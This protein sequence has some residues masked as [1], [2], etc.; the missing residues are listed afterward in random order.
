MELQANLR[1]IV[2]DD[3]PEIHKDFIKILTTNPTSATFESLDQKLF[4]EE[5]ESEKSFL[6]KFQI[7]TA[8]QGQEGVEKVRAAIAEKNPYALAF[9]DIRM[10]PGWDGIE[11]IKYIWQIDS[12]IQVVICTAYSDYSWEE[13]IEQLGMNDNLLILKKPFDNVAVRQL[14][15]ALTKKWLLMH[16]TREQMQLLEQRVN[17]RTSSLQ[18]SLSMIRATFESAADGILVVDN[19]E[20]IVDYNNKFIDLWRIPAAILEK[21]DSNLLF[22]YVLDQIEFPEGFTEKIK[23]IDAKPEL[24]NVDTIQ[25]KD[26][27]VLEWYT[28]PHKLNEAVI[29]RVWC[30]RDITEQETLE[31]RL[32]HQAT[33]DDLTDLPNRIL[34]ADRLKQAI[35]IAERDQTMVGVL[36]FDLDRFKLINDSFSHAAGDELL[37]AVAKRLRSA[38]RKQDTLA[39]LSGDEFVMI[40]TNLHNDGYLADITNKL[41]N[42][43]RQPFNIDNKEIIITTSI[44][45]S[46]FPQNGNTTEQLLRNA[47]LAMYRAKDVGA[48]QF[49]F[50]TPSLN[51][52]SIQRLELEAEL[53]RAINNQEFFLCYQPQVDLITQKIIAVEAL[54]RWQHPKRGV[55]L[56]MEF[57]PLAEEIGFIIPIGEWVLRKACQQN[58]MWQKQDLPFIRVAVNVTTP[59]IKHPNFINTVCTIL[60]ETGLGPEFLEIELTE[61]IIL[62]TKEIVKIVSELK[63]IGIQVVLDDFGT[64]NSSLNYLRSVPLDGLKIDRSFINNM[65]DRNNSDGV[66]LRA[67]ISMAN[68]LS[69][70][71]IAEG[72]ENQEQLKLL[73][74]Q[75]CREGQGYYFSKPLLAADLEKFLREKHQ[76]S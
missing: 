14:A 63:E 31:K 73:K 2:I 54:I 5:S 26:G 65:M 34:L 4:G 64:G 30:F 40:I 24:I 19:T 20:N 55:V 9:V 41:L 6:P 44:G 72:V 10:P 62:G 35:E 12:N 39:R 43:I 13:T 22:E 36:F 67:I 37:Q 58:K 17:E 21:K 32:E 60:K 69:L 18:K 48:N 28:Q 47:D 33:H 7:D 1:L 46:V 52:R 75:E 56:P 70:E 76:F 53:Q 42:V 29:G 27:R 11:T 25:F 16:E 8:I 68:G 66:I 49:Q 38:T 59:Q 74:A 51:E 61:N 57:I 45:I 50:Y 15:C 3:N 71:V 23:R